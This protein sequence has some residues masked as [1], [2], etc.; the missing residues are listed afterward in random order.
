MVVATLRDGDISGLSSVSS[1]SGGSCSTSP[2]A[3]ALLS[4]L[5]CSR[6]GSSNFGVD[7]SKPPVDSSDSD[8]TC[9][10]MMLSSPWGGDFSGDTSLD[11]AECDVVSKTGIGI[12]VEGSS[13]FSSDSELPS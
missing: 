13:L 2:A 10:W 3:L 8:F 9:T 4:A 11:E 7:A 12:G 6:A 5:V 1:G